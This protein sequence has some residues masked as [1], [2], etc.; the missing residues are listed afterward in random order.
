MKPLKFSISFVFYGASLGWMLRLLRR[1]RV[2][3]AIGVV[4]GM[5]LAG[6]MVVVV[7]QVVRGLPSH[8][9]TSTAL[10]ATLWTAMGLLIM[11]VMLMNL[12]TAALL[13]LQRGLEPVLAASVR[14][15]LVISFAGMATGFL[16]TEQ[17]SPSQQAAF[18]AGRQPA[19][20]GA[21]SVGVDDGGPGLPLVGWS[22]TGGDLRVPH[23]IGLHGLQ[24]LPVAGLLAN[25]VGQRLGTTR[26]RALVWIAGLGY[27]GLVVVLTWQA[28]RGQPVLAPDAAT[29]L[30]LGILAVA[31]AGG[32]A[33]LALPRPRPSLRT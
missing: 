8:F 9:N 18:H 4:T 22:T 17:L 1:R 31:V 25:R 7:I 30:A 21:H 13:G 5:A 23:F 19:S 16:M 20:E 12:L 10:D 29:L 6:E 28:L 11:P 24:V 15:G 33:L 2:A 32:T 14:W 26:R 3:A 27:L